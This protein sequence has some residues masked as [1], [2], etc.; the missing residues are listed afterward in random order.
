MP[1][2]STNSTVINR[3]N[4]GFPDY[5][6]F[7]ALRTSSIQYLSSLTG[8]LWTD[9][10]V[11]DPGITIL[12]VLLY[13]LLD[14]GYR[15]NLP[16]IDIF[17]KNP[18]DLSCENNFFT[19]AEILTCNPLTVTDFRKLLIDI[20]G[21]KNAWLKVAEDISLTNICEPHSTDVGNVTASGDSTANPCKNFING[22]YHIKLQLEDAPVRLREDVIQDVKKALLSHRNL[23]EDFIDISVLCS[24]PVG[25][26]A[27]IALDANADAAEVY[28][29][30]VVA[31][32]VFFSP[33]PIFYTLRQLLQKNKKID[34]IFA[35][36][37]YNHYNSQGFVDTSEFEAITLKEE[38]H[39]SDV[40]NIILGVPGVATVRKLKL[41]R[42]G[43][44]FSDKW[45][46]TIPADYVTI[47]S[48][49]IS[50][51]QF[52]I[53]GITVPVNFQ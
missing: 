42:D 21:V 14:L 15:T 46:F 26:C 25:I 19:P 24:L 1:D 22:L 3:T 51:L 2:Q 41:T 20:D 5:L 36:R 49:L 35:G 50:S 53:N 9:Y 27:D 6:D 39:L 8:K 45:L 34:E 44:H 13:A 11:H 23:C 37:P 18:A 38:I 43:V 29:D 17:T 16:A 10:N 47:F 32:Q 52:S 28:R 30:I 31:L 33:S 4:S 48:T 40:Y 12:E 7:D